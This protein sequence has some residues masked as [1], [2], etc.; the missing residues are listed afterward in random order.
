MNR[1]NETQKSSSASRS[2][3]S[4]TKSIVQEHKIRFQKKFGQNFLIDPRV[5]DKIV[6]AVDPQA[7]EGILEVGPGIGTLTQPMAERAKQVVAVEIDRHLVGIL[8]ETLAAYDNVRII[9]EDVLKVPV[10]EL[11][12]AFTGC[13][14]IKL[15]ANL[16]YNITSPL[17]MKMLEEA[18]F[19]GEMTLMV[20]EEVARRMQASP[21]GADYGALSLAVQYYARPEIAAFVPLNCFYP[22]PKVGSCVI[23]LTRH[24]QPPVEAKDEA[25]LFAVVRAAFNQ[26]RKM[27][28]NSLAN[29][30]ETFTKEEVAGALDQAGIDT[31]KRAQELSL[32]QFAMIANNLYNIRTSHSTEECV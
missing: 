17:I 18:P 1:P 20:Q 15:A 27:L 25:L 12:D 16:P 11:R 2:I 28:S 8:G 19:I 29:G 10:D 6:T 14:R 23:R 21:G 4:D 26:R 32:A 22:R 3:L 24:E 30:L 13:A 9:S 7:D 5:L 31:A